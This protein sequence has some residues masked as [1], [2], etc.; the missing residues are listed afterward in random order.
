MPG[1]E[2]DPSAG[3]EAPHDPYR[4]RR[5]IEHLERRFREES[6]M[7]ASAT[8]TT[9]E[10]ERRVSNE[11]QDF[12]TAS[13]AQLKQVVPALERDAQ[14]GLKETGEI[15]ARIDDFFTESKP[16]QRPAG[17]PDT[18]E[19]RDRRA[20]AGGASASA[21]EGP[22]PAARPAARA[23]PAV[24]AVPPAFADPTTGPAAP[25]TRR[26]ETKAPAPEAPPAERPKMDLKTA[27][28]RLRK[29]GTGKAAQPAGGP[30]PLPA[31]QPALAAPAAATP[32]PTVSP[33]AAPE[34]AA[35]PEAAA[36]PAARRAP[37]SPMLAQVPVAQPLPPS[38]VANAIAEQEIR[39]KKMDQTQSILPP[40]QREPRTGPVAGAPSFARRKDPTRSGLERSPREAA[41]ES[42]H[43]APAPSSQDPGR[44][45][46][47]PIGW[48]GAE[49][50]PRSA[51]PRPSA[52]AASAP[53]AAGSSV[54]EGSVRLGRPRS[55]SALEDVQA[56]LAPR[57]PARGESFDEIFN[58]LQ[59][60]VLDT[61]KESVDETFHAARKTDGDLR[62]PPSSATSPRGAAPA[63]PPAKEARSPRPARA[64]AAAPPPAAAPAKPSRLAKPADDDEDEDTREERDEAPKG[65]YDWGVKPAA[66][67]AGAW[68]VDGG[69]PAKAPARPAAAAP[70]PAPE[71]TADPNEISA[72]AGLGV[73]GRA[74]L[75]KKAGAEVK[76]LQPAVDALLK[77][78]VVEAKDLADP[79]APA[80]PAGSDD[81]LSIDSFANRPQ[82]DLE[83]ELS[84]VRLVEELRRLRRLSD[85]LIARG[86]ITAEDLSRAAE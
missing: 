44:S 79:A 18:N 70:E 20:R 9:S 5:E 25:K 33:I 11:M 73:G 14:S 34:P 40:L 45:Q 52:P 28:E 56:P 42:L 31:A 63:A 30:A 23:T 82:V 74:Y 86:V 6:P 75:I 38:V 2:P 60:L 54:R 61:L 69:E 85:A 80:A 72:G 84:P 3:P 68:L 39:W 19:L 62:A 46:L 13:E 37:E 24:A 7:P 65:P 53:G 67:P 49:P 1:P 50:S 21:P 78:G 12:F 32:V 71:R 83:K 58:E 77:K 76:K 55:L 41:R 22:A 51:P 64:P 35:A 10:V 57:A 47:P 26:P 66:K 15:R 81:E 17:V 8:T 36:P 59:G 4:R 27:L 16:E 48:G 29:H 43:A